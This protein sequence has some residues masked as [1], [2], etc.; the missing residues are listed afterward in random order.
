M[1]KSPV[2]LIACMMAAMFT[3]CE[4]IGSTDPMHDTTRLWPAYDKATRQWGYINHK[5]KMAIPAHF[6]QV[7]FFS[8]GYA[9]V[10]QNDMYHYINTDGNII[11][12][13]DEQNNYIGAPFYYNHVVMQQNRRY[14]LMNKNFEYV[15]QPIYEGIKEV[16]SNGLLSVK[17]KVMLD[18]DSTY[19]W[20]YINTKGEQV[21]PAQYLRTST[22]VDGF[23]PVCRY[24]QGWGV[25][26]ETGKELIPCQNKT[27]YYVGGDMFTTYSDSG[28]GKKLLNANAENIS[29]PNIRNYESAVDNELI[30]IVNN[31]GLFGYMDFDRNIRIPCQYDY[32][33]PFFEGYAFVEKEINDDYIIQV[34]DTKG[35]VICTL[36]DDSE[37]ETGF[38]NGL[39]LIVVDMGEAEAYRYITPKGEVIYQWLD[40]EVPNC[41]PVR[42]LADR[43]GTSPHARTLTAEKKTLSSTD[44][45]TMNSA[46]DTMMNST[47]DTTKNSADEISTNSDTQI[48]VLQ[49]FTEQTLHFSSR[50]FE[51]RR[52]HACDPSI[53]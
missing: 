52:A 45:T 23:A 37:P 5:G 14:G 39:A 24:P 51:Q 1:K 22:F 31:D 9:F 46:D 15:V 27:L 53:D 7:D 47:D 26:D 6:D 50:R 49:E 21:V 4:Q 38:H 44:N 43:Y 33:M 11:Y 8:C 12:T 17:Q 16:G 32:A 30:V 48:S 18:G 25:I 40:S 29:L 19:A 2:L 34:I 28:D 13:I 3:S 41:S 10:E 35:K 20:G 42:R 36:P